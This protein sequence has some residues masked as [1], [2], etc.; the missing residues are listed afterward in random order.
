MSP[1][2]PIGSAADVGVASALVQQ[3]SAIT[4]LVAHLTAQA[5][6]FSDLAIGSGA[7]SSTSTKGSQRRERMQSDLA[8]GQSAYFLTMMQQVHKRLN[9]GKPQPR[10][11]TELTNL[12]FLTYL[13]RTGGYKN[14]REAG[15]LMWLLGHVIDAASENNTWLV[16]ERL[17][18]AVV[19]LEQSVVDS[20][21]WTL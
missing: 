6:P 16:R 8:N 18:L 7:T 21:D 3:S 2:D 1:S 13:E 12:S 19:A 5:D 15:L 10:V 4:A 9:P 14:S 17:A 11:E 20:G